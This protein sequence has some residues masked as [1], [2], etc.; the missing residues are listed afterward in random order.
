MMP[1]MLTRLAALV[2]AAGVSPPAAASDAPLQRALSQA[3]CSGAR[4][5][6]LVDEGKTTIYRANCSGSSHRRLVVTCMED[7]CRTTPELETPDN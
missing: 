1:G 6:R 7:T 5:E 3:A 4:L 2:C